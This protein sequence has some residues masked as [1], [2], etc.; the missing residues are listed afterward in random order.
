MNARLSIAKSNFF[1][2]S[3]TRLA[4]ASEMFGSTKE[5][6]GAKIDALAAEVTRMASNHAEVRALACARPQTVRTPEQ[7]STL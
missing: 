6:L 1:F 2:W 4:S 3:H 5:K 7:P